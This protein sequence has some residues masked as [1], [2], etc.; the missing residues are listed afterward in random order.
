[1]LENLE[2]TSE[3]LGHFYDRLENLS[4]ESSGS[5]I[6]TTML[7]KA[8]SERDNRSQRMNI[9]RWFL[10]EQ[11]NQSVLNSLNIADSLTDLGEFL[12]VLMTVGRL[13]LEI[14]KKQLLILVDEAEK[15]ANVTDQDAMY[16][17]TNAVRELF[18]DDNRA[19]GIAFALG[20]GRLDSAEIPI[21]DERAVRSRLAMREINLDFLPPEDMKA[22][23]R[24]MINEL[25]VEVCVQ[26]VIS[27]HDNI[28]VDSY[29]FTEDT[30]ADFVASITDDPALSKPRI[31]IKTLNECVAEAFLSG[32]RIIDLDVLDAV[33][34]PSE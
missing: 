4:G 23:V 16:N 2:S 29:P 12:G 8:N 9:W 21:F 6:I 3:N 14:D 26:E 10:G 17:W 13:F 27:A 25:T 15:L 22:F 18:D 30:W 1:M 19:I 24:D 20:A 31:A 5:R 34:P 7:R 11:L 28:S 32:K 33:P